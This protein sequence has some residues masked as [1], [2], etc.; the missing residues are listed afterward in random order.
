MLN[1]PEWMS[2]ARYSVMG[3]ESLLEDFPTDYAQLRMLANCF[4]VVR[5]IVFDVRQTL[6]CRGATTN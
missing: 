3:C 2:G 6:A 1:T 4:R 5:W